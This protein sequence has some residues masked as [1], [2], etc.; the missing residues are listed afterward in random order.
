MQTVNDVVKVNMTGSDGKSVEYTKPVS[1]PELET[2]DD[3]LTF[4]SDESKLKDLIA[5]ANYGFNLKARAKVSQQIK[6]ENAGPENSINKMVK[7]M[8][9]ARTVLGRPIS[10]EDARKVVLSMLG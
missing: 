7:D 5:A 8:V 2:A 6:S 10:E 4:V 3:V 1:F 9:K